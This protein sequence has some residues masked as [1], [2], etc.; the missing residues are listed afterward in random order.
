MRGVPFLLL[1][2]LLFGSATSPAQSQPR[3]RARFIIGSTTSVRDTGLLD[4]LVDRF[5][6][7]TGI[8]ATAVAVGTGEALRMGERGDA[9]LLIVHAPAQEKA[10]MEAGYGSARLTFLYNDFVLAG[11]SSDPAYVAGTAIIEAFRAIARTRSRFASRGDESGT[12]IRERE[13]WQKAGLEPSGDWY[14]RTG[15]GMAETLRIAEELQAYVLTDQATLAVT[16]RLT[17]RALVS[18]D[19]LLANPYS[20]ITVQSSR[21]P[22][23]NAEAA[24]AFMSFLQED[25]TRAFMADFGRDRV[26]RPLFR[27]A[28]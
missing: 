23:V 6:R 4:A 9:D 3:E 26:G 27:L 20:A 1:P 12:N 24:R 11:P 8:Q 18:G 10:F 17:V 25:G 15:Q 14:V 28:P 22:Q 13:L 7:E 19:P 16:A 5:A 21:R 2:F